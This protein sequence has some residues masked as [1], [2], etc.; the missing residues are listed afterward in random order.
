LGG[1]DFIFVTTPDK[2]E[3]LSQ[4]IANTFDKG[5]APFYDDDARVS[6]FI[7]IPDRRNRKC[8]YPLLSVTI[9]IT[10]PDSKKHYGEIMKSVMELK[11]YGKKIAPRNGGSIF[12]RDRRL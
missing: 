12:V 6:G 4:T 3:A 11:K 8:F 2:C 9:S 10:T 7:S 1:D 5:I